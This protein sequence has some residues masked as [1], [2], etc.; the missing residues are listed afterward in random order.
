MDLVCKLT[1]NYV[2]YCYEKSKKK[3][4]KLNSSIGRVA[5]RETIVRMFSFNV[6]W[7]FEFIVID[8]VCSQL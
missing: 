8:T 4:N 3:S 1:A 6:F 7:K 5:K 2:I